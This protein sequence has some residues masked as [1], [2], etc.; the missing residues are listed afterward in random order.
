MLKD[1][2][3]LE[4]E[5]KSLLCKLVE[6]ERTLPKGKRGK[7]VAV[8]SDQATSAVFLYTT[9]P[10]IQVSGSLT[11]AEILAENGLLGLTYNARGGRLFHIK[12]EAL[13]YYGELKQV[14]QP[15]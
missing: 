11:D 9:V 3:L 1:R 10:G 12:P 2:I 5:Q 6:A 15:A 4:P 13:Q 7:F 8:E 14:S